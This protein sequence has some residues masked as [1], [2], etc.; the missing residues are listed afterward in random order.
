MYYLTIYFM[1]EYN[2]V[3]STKYFIKLLFKFFIIRI[4]GSY[5]QYSIIYAKK[6]TD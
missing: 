4:K 2:L 3:Y 5:E 1:G 6:K